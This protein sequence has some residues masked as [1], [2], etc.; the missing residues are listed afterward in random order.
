MRELSEIG[1][2]WEKAAI[3]LGDKK[4]TADCLGAEMMQLEQKMLQLRGELEEAEKA[5]KDAADLLA[6]VIEIVSSVDPDKERH[7]REK[8]ERWTSRHRKPDSIRIDYLTVCKAFGEK[9][10]TR[11]TLSAEMD[12]LTLGM[13]S[14]RRESVATSEQVTP[15]QSV[16]A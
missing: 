3:A 4:F 9:E 11:R 13:E 7:R 16:A 2:D 14:L 6:P 10:F 1:N 15:T 8:A 12:Q 5:H